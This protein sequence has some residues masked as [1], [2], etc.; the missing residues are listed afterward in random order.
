MTE[1]TIHRISGKWILEP[2]TIILDEATAGL[3]NVGVLKITNATDFKLSDIHI[4]ST[5]TD[6]IF[7]TIALIMPKQTGYVNMTF[8]CAEEEDGPVTIDVRIE[9]IGRRVTFG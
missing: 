1:V 5:R 6:C 8:N 7:E 4:H 2:S 9:A 3:E